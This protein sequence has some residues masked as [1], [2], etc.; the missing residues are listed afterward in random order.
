[1]DDN[2]FWKLI[3]PM[4]TVASDRYNEKM[5]VEPTIHKEELRKRFSC[6]DK[7]LDSDDE[8]DDCVSVTSDASV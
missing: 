2:F 7:E 5:L 6:Q 1:M 8:H 4:K 3:Q